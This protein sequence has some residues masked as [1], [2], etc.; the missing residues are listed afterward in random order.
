[1]TIS[2][3]VSVGDQGQFTIPLKTIPLDQTGPTA[4]TKMSIDTPQLNHQRPQNS[5]PQQGEGKLGQPE[6]YTPEDLPT[7]SDRPDADVVIF[8]GKCVFCISQVRKLLW[9]DGGKRLSYMSLHDPETS[10]RFP[11][12]TYDQLMKQMYVVD[13]AGHRFGGADAV[14]YLSRRLPKLW[15]L[16]PLT[17]FPFTMP[18]QRWVYSRIAQRRYEIA[19][20]DGLECEGGT[21]D[22]HFGENSKE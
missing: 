20:K 3:I 12:L 19:N 1:M 10:I 18:I 16:S 13:R 11:D 22:L 4:P 8:D 15:G 14:R 6:R 21:C 17:H 5:E 7:P 2:F 9:L